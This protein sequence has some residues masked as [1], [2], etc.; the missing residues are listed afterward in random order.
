MKSF[1]P[2]VLLG[3][4]V[5]SGGDMSCNGGCCGGGSSGN[6]GIAG[7]PGVTDFFLFD[8]S[9][10]FARFFFGFTASSLQNLMLRIMK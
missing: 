4:L 6:G 2:F 5:V 9:D 8:D 7:G 1:P 3:V 10:N